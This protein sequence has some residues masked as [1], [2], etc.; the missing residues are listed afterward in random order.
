MG[1]ERVGITS[2]ASTPELLVNR[3]VEYLKP[4]AV[5]SV[6]VM[7]ENVRFLLPKSLR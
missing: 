4:T 3:V 7:E 5:R 2:G 6:E 1:A